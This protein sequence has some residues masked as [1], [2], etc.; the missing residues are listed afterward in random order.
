MQ[1]PLTGGQIRQTLED[2]GVE[3]P[4]PIVAALLALREHMPL[5]ELG[6]EI[7]LEVQE[8]AQ[9]Q[10]DLAEA[11]RASGAPMPRLRIAGVPYSYNNLANAEINPPDFV[12]QLL[13]QLG[14][15]KLSIT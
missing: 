7:V 9:E 12:G 13:N 1:R 2:A 11:A 6:L 15:G 3:N 8:R 10:L 5:P 4:G 14:M